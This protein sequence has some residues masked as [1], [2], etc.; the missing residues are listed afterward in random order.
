MAPFGI[1]A[2]L[3]VI[4]TGRPATDESCMDQ[5]GTGDTVGRQALHGDHRRRDRRHRAG[6]RPVSVRVSYTGSARTPGSTIRWSSRDWRRSA[7]RPAQQPT[8]KTTLPPVGMRHISRPA[9]GPRAYVDAVV[10][11]GGPVHAAFT[12]TTSARCGTACTTSWPTPWASTSGQSWRSS[13]PGCAPS[14]G[15]LARH[16]RQRPDVGHQRR[17][18][19]VRTCRRH[20]DVQRRRDTEIMLIEGG[21][22]CAFNRYQ[23]SSTPC[24]VAHDGRHLPASGNARSHHPGFL[25]RCDA[26]RCLRSPTALRR[27]VDTPDL[28]RKRDD[29]F[30]C[31]EPFIAAERSMF[32]GRRTRL[33]RSTSAD[34]Q[35]RDADSAASIDENG[36]H[37]F[38]IV[39]A[40]WQ[41]IKIVNANINGE[42]RSFV[43][44]R[45]RNR[46]S[47][48]A[49][50]RSRIEGVCHDSP[51]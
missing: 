41:H 29:A 22:H 31:G 7:R 35:I 13:C 37:V 36:W 48:A 27:I 46:T 49:S 51:R 11:I 47:G 1:L 9:H 39:L 18:R 26:G 6:R 3:P 16:G 14:P 17:R 33:G 21:G 34:W 50:R 23:R 45:P 30:C 4:G 15:T 10:V 12:N 40:S 20:A 19:S 43:E 24:K 5:C 38:A 2:A 32:G 42:I 25:G 44:A 28:L 8:T